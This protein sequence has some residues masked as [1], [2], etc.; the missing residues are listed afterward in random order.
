M[1]FAYVDG[2]LCC[3]GVDLS[4]IARECDTPVYVY[5]ANTILDR[6]HAYDAA[7]AD[8]PHSVCYAVKAN[9]NINLLSCWRARALGSTSYP[10]ASCFAC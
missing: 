4:Q 3:D 6:F 10:A 1:P 5:S 8:L 7:L 2:R 9:S